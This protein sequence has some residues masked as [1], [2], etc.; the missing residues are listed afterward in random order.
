[1]GAVLSQPITS[2]LLQRRGNKNF[3]VGSSEMQG[4]RMAME[5]THCI[6]PK[7]SDKHPNVGLFGVFDGHA[8]E[9]ASIYLEADL[10]RRISA[11]PD[12]TDIEALRAATVQMDTDFCTRTDER[13]DGSTCCFCVV[14]SKTEGKTWEVIAVNVGDSRAM[15]VKPDGSVIDLTKDHKPEDYEEAARIVR[16]GGEVR[17]N[18]VDGQLAMSRAIGDWQ[19]KKDESIPQ[20]EQKVIPLPDIQTGT[21]E[22]G[23]VLVV[24]CDGIVEQATN[25][26]VGLNV[27]QSMDAYTS[28]AEVDPAQVMLKLLDYS[29]QRGSKDNHSSML[30]LFQDGRAYHND[31]DQFIAG[32]FHPYQADKNFVKAYLSDAAKHGYEGEELM[33]LARQTEASLPPVETVAG[34]ADDGAN[35]AMA[36][37]QAFLSRPGELNDR[38]S[39]LSNLFTQGG[40]PGGEEP[41]AEGGAP[42]TN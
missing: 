42:P 17:S 13:E 23:D 2:Q 18:R 5:D 33:E 30:V 12:P 22:P 20:L 4:Y 35:P 1:M 7:L 25:E 8:G 40:A 6:A 27:K 37:L 16:A 3:M 19:Y 39:L 26:D 15:I 21:A 10:H 11:M 14:H 34:P 9:R 24:C 41:P 29:L 32:P 38:L 31:K 28:R 36:A